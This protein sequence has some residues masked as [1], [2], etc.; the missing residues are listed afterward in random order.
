MSFADLIGNATA[1]QLLKQELMTGR[2]SHTYLFT[3][4]TG[5]GKRSLGLAW[6]QSL[7]C[8]KPVQGDACGTCASCQRCAADT[9]PDLA[10]FEGK[11]GI[12]Q[13]R[14]LIRALSL[15]PHGGRRKVGVIDGAEELTEEATH[16]TLKLL[17][18]PPERSVLILTAAQPHRLPSTLL[19]R[20]HVVRCLPQ[21]IDPVASFLQDQ[22]GLDSAQACLLANASGGRIG[23]ALALHRD[24]LLAERNAALDQILA[25]LKKGEIELPLGAAPREELKSAL[26]W[27]ASFWRDLLV[28]KLKGD[29][30]WVIHQDR[31]R[32]L[33]R[34]A[35]R[36]FSVE[37]LMARI[38]QVYGV[39]RC[40]Q[41]NASG[42]LALGALL[43]HR[44]PRR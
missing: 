5:T 31:L 32:E 40:L 3:G 24:D 4:A 34:A 23:L 35:E 12:D 19:S 21:G 36:P 1:Q 25:A 2:V 20:C 22:E 10:R 29:P 43:S 37:G 14:A 18:E 16:A 27:T 8:E 33:Q 30:R 9:S 7:L 11:L 6:A 28:L 44:V 26:E 39:E 15:T 17:E 41:R 38:Q 13:V 42:R